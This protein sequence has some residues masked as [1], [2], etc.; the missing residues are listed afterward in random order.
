MRP[1]D[2]SELDEGEAAAHWQGRV[3]LLHISPIP[4]HEE[5]RDVLGAW[6]AHVSRFGLV[7][8]PN[9]VAPLVAPEQW[10]EIF[11]TAN[12]RIFQKL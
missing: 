3:R 9:E 5:T 1:R 11:A 10:T 2:P 8:L 4:T 6:S 7:V 12:I